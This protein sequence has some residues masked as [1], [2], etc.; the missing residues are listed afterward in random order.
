MLHVSRCASGPPLR[1]FDWGGGADVSLWEIGCHKHRLFSYFH[2]KYVYLLCELNYNASNS[3]EIA[4]LSLHY[5]SGGVKTTFSTVMRTLLGPPQ[6]HN[7]DSTAG[8]GGFAVGA[9]A[10]AVNMLEEALMRLETNTVA[11]TPRL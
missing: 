9:A 11:P 2:V 7:F 3:Q 10:P 1:N 5:S 6:C 4:G 8:V